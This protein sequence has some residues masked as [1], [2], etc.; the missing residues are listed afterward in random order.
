MNDRRTEMYAS[1]QFL[2][3]HA[4]VRGEHAFLWD[5]CGRRYLDFATS[6]GVSNTGHNHPRVVEAIRAQAGRLFHLAGNVAPH[7]PMLRL[8]SV[9]R[10]V[11]PAELPD[12]CLTGSE[13]EAVELAIRLARHVTGRPNLIVFQRGFHGHTIA[14]VNLSTA[15]AWQCAGNPSLSCRTLVAPYPYCYRCPKA[16]AAPERYSA[17]SCCGWPLEQVRFLLKS[18]TVPQETAA[19]LVEPILGEGGC[20]V[21]PAPFLRGLRDIC[22]EFGI[23]LLFDERCTGFGRSGRFFALEH[24]GVVP[25]ILILSTGLPLGAVAARRGLLEDPHKEGAWD[26]PVPS[27]VAC[28]ATEVALRVLEEEQLVKNSAIMGEKLRS[29]LRALQQRYPAIGEVRGQGLMVGVEF[30]VPGGRTPDKDRTRDTQRACLEAGLLLATC[31]TDD[32]V[33][34]WTPPLIIGDPELDEALSIFEHSLA[35]VINS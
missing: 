18:Q 3:G 21:A 13:S 35:G 22:R 17:G 27:P 24:S 25:D 9:L 28:S 23:L 33:L 26:V 7:E 31:G 11:V 29:R 6:V 15:K 1:P 32:N 19:I 20:V 34:R 5:E 10:D 4:V 14:A 12:I 16:E 30:V 2:L 8:V